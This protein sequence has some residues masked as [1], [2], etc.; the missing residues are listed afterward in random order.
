[1]ISD[2]SWTCSASFPHRTMLELISD[3]QLSEAFAR[4]ER[5][6]EPA[7]QATGELWIGIDPATGGGGDDSVIYI[8][9]GHVVLECDAFQGGTDDVARLKC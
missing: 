9:R 5:I 2:T 8:R 3:E 7:A 1:M 6:D 4:H